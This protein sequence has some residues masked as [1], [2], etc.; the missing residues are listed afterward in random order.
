MLA[1]TPSV[2]RGGDFLD[3]LAAGAGESSMRLAHYVRV[4]RSLGVND[5]DA[6]L[7]ALSG[8]AR[9]SALVETMGR[10]HLV[11]LLL[12]A[13]PEDALRACLPAEALIKLRAQLRRARS[14][15]LEDL[16]TIA[17]TQAA[18]RKEG[19]DCMVLKGLYFA[20]RLYGGLDRR[21]QLDIDLIVRRR[22]FRDA[23]RTLRALG[24]VERW[25][26]LHSINWARGAARIDLHSCFRR[27]PVYRLDEERIWAERIPYAIEGIPFSTPSD[28]HTLVLLALSLFQDIGL[29]AAKLKQLLDLYLLASSIDARFDWR[30][31]FAGRA[32]DGTLGVAANV[33]DLALRV[34]DAQSELPRL[35]EALSHHLRLLVVSDREQALALLF[36]ERAARSSKAWFFAVYPGS[37]VLYWLWLLPRKVP[38]YLKGR[39][40]QR[41]PSSMFPSLETVRALLGARRMYGRS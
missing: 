17:E 7:A 33:L 13:A 10:H 11:A 26:D 29:G 35:C 4:A 14:S 34:F 18:F 3:G 38:M 5:T 41:G 36:A 8:I 31:F 40:P 30:G 21:M 9:D 1:S 2:A 19:V 24:Y 39:A 22:D 23:S 32:Q 37:I 25:R 27:T 6:A 12:G 15:P 16:G 20:H 28:A